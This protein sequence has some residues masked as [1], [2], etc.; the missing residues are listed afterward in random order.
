MDEDTMTL[1]GAF[2]EIEALKE[3]I[4]TLEKERDEYLNGWKRA[5]ADYVNM[6][7]DQE[8]R[9]G[10]L[11]T[12]ARM[13]ALM[14]YLPIIENF[15]KAFTYLPTDLATSDWV[16]GVEQIY[17]QMKDVL[18]EMGVEEITNSV[19]APFDP[20]IHEAVGNEYIDTMEEN[21]VTQEVETGYRHNTMVMV[22]ARVI[23]NKRP[24]ESG[25]T[26]QESG[27]DGADSHN[28]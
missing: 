1:E 17:K 6:K 4:E 20:S 28:S 10:E 16:K 12:V 19:G 22:P 13:A 7:N 25:I 11:A 24:K 26:N 2:K 18:K 15:R 14:R 9:S 5:K 23:V 3:K 27:T 21:M 8:K